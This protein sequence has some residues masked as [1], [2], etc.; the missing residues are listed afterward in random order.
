MAPHSLRA[1]TEGELATLTATATGPIHLHI[2][3]QTGEVDDCLA[4]SGARPVEWLMDR[5]EVDRRWCL[6]HAT[7][8]TAAETHRLAESGAVA[9][10]C[11][12]TEA[13]LGDGLFPA[14]SFLD[15]GGAFGVGSDSNVRIDASEELRLLE[16][17]QR[18]TGRARNV[19]A[20]GQNGSTGADLCRGAL[21]GGAQALGQAITGLTPGASADIVTLKG[22]HPDLAWRRGDQLIDSWIFAGGMQMVDCVWRYGRKVVTQGRH[23]AREAVVPR[24]RATLERIIP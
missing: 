21:A 15:A 23:E 5:F 19:L 4:W 14:K 13:N 2:A 22:D 9:G 11:P 18:L 16:Y 3:E 17:G 12:I 10:L 24:Y 8:M 20:R 6:V 1:V 7:H